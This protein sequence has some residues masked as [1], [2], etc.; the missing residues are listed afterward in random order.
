MHAESKHRVL[1]L[2][3]P[4]GEHPGL[5]P[6]AVL[7]GSQRRK[8]SRSTQ[9]AV[10]LMHGMQNTCK[11]IH[12]LVLILHGLPRS[13]MVCRTAHSRKLLKTLAKGL[14]PH[15]LQMHPWEKLWAE[16]QQAG[17]Q[18]VGTVGQAV[19]CDYLLCFGAE[20]SRGRW[21]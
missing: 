5:A 7:R 6:E 19:R 11:L 12:K 2:P 21:G 1:S 9:G 4:G 16:A 13:S 14:L 18:A 8:I 20:L 10:G 17:G 15:A 3:Y